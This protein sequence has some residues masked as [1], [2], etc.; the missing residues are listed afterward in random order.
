[1]TVHSSGTSEKDRAVAV[2]GAAGHTGRFVV[3]ELLRRGITPIA[4]ARNVAK[5]A[6]F[7]DRGIEVRG[8]SIDDPESLD[9]AF[10]GA[11]AVINCAGPFLD[12]ADAVASA[13]LRAGIHYLDV[14]AEQP[15]A[16]AIYDK[17]DKAARDAG[18]LFVPAM[19][20]YGGFADLLVTTAMGD[21]DSADE[22]RVGIALDSWHPTEGTRI[23][24]A[25][26]TARRMIVAN[27]AL[28]PVV[29]PA[30]EADWNFPEPFGQ[31]KVVEL[32][33]SEIVVIARHTRSSEL[34]TYLNRTALS[35]VRDPATPAPEP[36]DENGRSA[37]IFLVEATVR[38]GEQIRR[39]AAEGRDIYAFSAPLIS[40][41][42]QRILDGRARGSGAQAPGAIFDARDYLN[43]LAPDHLSL[44][45]AED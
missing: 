10:K 41:A 24:G 16:Q 18:V 40:E 3:S 22:I 17:F 7:A 6:E 37:Q 44:A 23:T 20:F 45:V 28:V 33:F 43:A 31:Q 29:Q 27:G 19:G 8:T 12:T 21:W 39:I 42:V 35:D 15:S 9:Q 1:M 32:P 11:A 2:F 38:K 26:N 5:L 13:A 25:K 30:A 36:A 34:R 14:T 4:V